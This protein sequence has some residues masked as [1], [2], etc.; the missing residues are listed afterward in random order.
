VSPP[1]YFSTAVPF[2]NTQNM[3]K[4]AYVMNNGLFVFG[5]ENIAISASPNLKHA[6]SQKLNI[7]APYWIDTKPN[8]GHVNYHLYEKCGQD[9]YDGTKDDSKSPYMIKVMT[10]ANQD[11][12]K[13]YGFIGFDVEKVLV[14]TW[15]DVQD[16]YG[17]D[18]ITF[19][20]VFISGWKKESQN[21]QEI[22]AGELTSYVIF[23]YQQGKMN[24]PYIAGRLISIGFTGNNLPFT[25]T[26]LASRLDKMKGN[27]GFNGVFTYK[28]G[29][30]SS[31][32]QKCHS[33][34]CS[35]IDLLSSPVYEN[36]KRTLYGCPCTMERLGAQWQLYETR[37]E[38][39]DIECYAISH[40]AKKRLLASN[41]RNKLCCYKREKTQNPNDW[42]DV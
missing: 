20:A 5:D 28:T 26:F 18:T 10:R 11:L 16:I 37:G 12:I 9:A 22:Q 42:R 30:S 17:T 41:I 39:N 29:S 1:I 21:G 31:S 19:Q 13:Y 23:M 4:V 32:L 14:L 6:L 38:K 7:V 25:N 36:D 34:T 15:V 40:I 35:K 33:Y 24:W 8:S 27:T 3:H 2:G